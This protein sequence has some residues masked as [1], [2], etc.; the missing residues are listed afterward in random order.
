[1]SKQYVPELGQAVFGAA[2]SEHEMPDFASALLETLLVMVGNAYWNREQKDWDWLVDPK[3][4]G[5]EFRPYYWGDCDCGY[6][7]D[8]EEW[9]ETHPHAATCYQ[10]D[11]AALCDTYPKRFS[12]EKRWNRAA[13]GLCKKHG[14]PW[15]NGRGE[16]V[17]CTCGRKAKWATWSAEHNH[18]ATCSFV[19]PNFKFEDV[20]IRWYK[21]PGRGMSCNRKMT[22]RQWRRWFDR[23]VGVIRAGDEEIE[24]GRGK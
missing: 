22:E 23:C 11:Y 5:I 1:M 12:E 24:K 3:I 4:P 21:N 15:N 13:R 18:A 17:H 8:E 20:E 2:W 16:V 6:D 14:I 9:V 7:E 10:A 19:L